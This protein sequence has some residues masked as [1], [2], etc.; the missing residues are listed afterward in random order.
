MID[1]EDIK[2]FIELAKD[3][4]AIDDS[5]NL[6]SIV[7]RL[8]KQYGTDVVLDSLNFFTGLLIKGQLKGNLVGGLVGYCNKA[9]KYT[10]MDNDNYEP[11][12]VTWVQDLD[13]TGIS[14]AIEEF[15]NRSGRSE[16]IV[17]AWSDKDVKQEVMFLRVIK[18]EW[19]AIKKIKRAKMEYKRRQIWI[20][21]K[22]SVR[23]MPTLLLKSQHEMRIEEY[24]DGRS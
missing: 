10:A 7:R 11:T 6:Y 12:N 22:K 8:K 5:I 23:N 16:G 4:E 9:A 15:S 17:S 13:I 2:K 24:K 20:S 3:C 14:T 18:L 19:E 21:Y 1:T